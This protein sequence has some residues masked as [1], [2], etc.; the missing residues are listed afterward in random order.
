MNPV[1]QEENN[2]VDP[3]NNRN[4]QPNEPNSMPSRRFST[5]T[6]R[7]LFEVDGRVEETGFDFLNRV[8]HNNA[9]IGTKPIQDRP[10]GEPSTAS[11]SSE[12]RIADPSSAIGSAVEDGSVDETA[13]YDTNN[14][15]EEH[16]N[17]AD[18]AANDMNVDD[19]DDVNHVNIESGK[20]YQFYLL[21]DLIFVMMCMISSNLL[22]FLPAAKNECAH[23]GGV[24]VESI[25]SMHDANKTKDRA[26]NSSSD[27]MCGNGPNG[28]NQ[29]RQLLA[30]DGLHG[31]QGRSVLFD[32]F[33]RTRNVPFNIAGRRRSI[34]VFSTIP[35][36]DSK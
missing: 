9:T 4:V 15:S 34:S 1:D 14:S 27:L 7:N 26:E 29:Q 23:N 5:A 35:E 36:N 31:S 2:E 19:V 28:A 22:W 18:G 24:V 11:I 20:F 21:F 17:I 16:L 33:M 30:A 25:D 10:S 6:C 12:I 13:F 8:P 32:P 3:S